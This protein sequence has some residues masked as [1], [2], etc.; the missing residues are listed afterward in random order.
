[1]RAA[2][3]KCHVGHT[4]HILVLIAFAATVL[5]VSALANA[6]FTAQP[7]YAQ[8]AKLAAGTTASTDDGVKTQSSGYTT[9]AKIKLN[10]TSGIIKN[11]GKLK[12]K[13]TLVPADPSLPIKDTSIEWSVS[14]PKVARITQDGIVQGKKTGAIWVMA[15]AS[16]GVRAYALVKVYVNKKR[17]ATRIPVLTYHRICSDKAKRTVYSNT[18]LAISRS[19][20]QRQMAWLKKNGYYTVSTSEFADW[21]IEG[22]YLPKKSVLITIDDGFYETYHIAYPILRKYN[23]KATS[24]VIGSRVPKRTKAYSSSVSWSRYV[25]WDVINRLRTTYPN[26]EFQS[27][28]YNMHHRSGGVGVAKKWSRKRIDADFKKNEKFGFTAIAYPFGHTSKNL[29]ASVRANP[30]IRI[31][32]GYMMEHP[33]ARTSPLYNIPRFKVFGDRGL[34]DF[35]RIVRTAK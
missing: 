25:G 26:L 14:K 16:N 2:S 19:N 7:A 23:L 17:N 27:H 9:V 15:T 6:A 13:A 28:T 8:E 12:F 33:A 22:A 20:F 10:K 34:E 18:N 4:V 35:K 29:L 11:N 3:A 31:G 21:R 5:V 32:F 1:M 24:F 30:N